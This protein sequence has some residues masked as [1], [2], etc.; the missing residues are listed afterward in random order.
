MKT[1]IA[2][3]LLF[4]TLLYSCSEPSGESAVDEQD[5][6][7]SD[8]NS[9]KGEEVMS[10]QIDN[11]TFSVVPQQLD[12][13]IP[14]LHSF[15]E[16]SYA[17]QWIIIGGQTVGFH[18]TSNNP[19][20]FHTSFANDSLWVIDPE[21]GVT[22][23]APIP[24]QYWN[25]L[26]ASNSQSYQVD[27]K[28]YVCG[29]YTVSDSSQSRF[30]TTSNYFFEIDLANFIAYVK[31]GGLNPAVEDVFTIALQDEFISVSGGEMIVANG[32]FYLVGGQNYQGAYSAGRTGN[33]TD[34]IRSFT[35]E[36]SGDMW[37]L[38]N[39]DSLVDPVNLHRRDFNLVPFVAEGGSL[40]AIL[41]GGVFTP[42]DL[43]YNNPVYINGLSQ[44]NPSITVDQ[45]EQKCNQ[46]TCAIV[47]MYAEEGQSMQYAL[48]GGITYMMYSQDSSKLVIG[49]QIGNQNIPM[50]FSNL[51]TRLLSDGETT[52]ESVQLP[53]AALL[54]KYLGSNAAFF[55]LPQ[56]ALD[57]FESIINLDQ[58]VAETT[59]GVT[60]GYMYGGILF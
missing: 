56:F 9:V 35:L 38:A 31:S 10:Q 7:T 32:H 58:V 5:A 19:P 40:E 18:G 1:N 14:A 51:I 17:N 20:P 25:A 29:G 43:S 3:Q 53:P 42:N 22:Y 6:I 34:A 2:L 28:L 13:T 46:Y 23:G 41:Y 52:T 60:I 47:P 12:Y 57:G 8:V 55:A 4:L 24:P 36:Q 45:I 50:P 54:P 21:A 11:M 15:A 16:A 39:K 48:L 33:Y 37:L 26:C 59:D 44:G 30:N 27:D 49:D